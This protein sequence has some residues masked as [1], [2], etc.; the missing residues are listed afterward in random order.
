MF[1]LA[2]FLLGF[3]RLKPT[4]LSAFSSTPTFAEISGYCSHVPPILAEEFLERQQR[5]VDTLVSLNASAYVTE[6]GPS[7]HY[8]ANLSSWEL[9]ERP[10]LLIISPDASSRPN[11]TILSPF[12]EESRVRLMTIPSRKPVSY[13]TWREEV[14]PYR[15]AV[16]AIPSMGMGR[17]VFVDGEMRAFVLNGLLTATPSAQ[18]LLAPVEV[19]RLRQR[20]SRRELEIM[21]R[22]NEV[23]RKETSTANCVLTMIDRQLF[24]LFELSREGCISASLNPRPVL[25][26][27]LHS[28]PPACQMVMALCFLEVG[29]Q[30]VKI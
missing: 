11:V 4:V 6:P 12:F 30:S 17:P 23:C 8:Y 1:L 19:Q 16:D 24:W 18:V 26:L 28:R 10:L 5:L 29:S 3:N 25:S 9:S 15:V 14:S 27:N 7:A 22:A 2:A 21:M 13:A 20:K